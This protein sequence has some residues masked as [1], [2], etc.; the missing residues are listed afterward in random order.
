MVDF[1]L[2]C[3]RRWE[4]SSEDADWDRFEWV[5]VVAMNLPLVSAWHAHKR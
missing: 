4:S 5:L 1:R 3:A 2:R